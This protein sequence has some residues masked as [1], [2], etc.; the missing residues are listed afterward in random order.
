[1]LDIF[2]NKKKYFF[3]IEIDGESEQQQTLIKRKIN[4]RVAVL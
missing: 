1:M 3:F 4:Q 2:L